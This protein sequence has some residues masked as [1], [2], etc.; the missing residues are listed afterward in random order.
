MAKVAE[1]AVLRPVVSQACRS[2]KFLAF[3]SKSCPEPNFLLVSMVTLTDV[4]KN[5][6]GAI[7]IFFQNIGETCGGCGPPRGD[8]V[9]VS[10]AHRPAR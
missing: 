9:G 4:Y 10:N 1:V 6:L 7:F 3:G 2:A 8:V 5:V